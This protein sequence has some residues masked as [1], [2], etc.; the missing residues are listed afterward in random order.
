MVA[1]PR[2]VEL[3]WV[4]LLGVFGGRPWAP[5]HLRVR[6]AQQVR[7]AEL[8]GEIGL[9]EIRFA[10]NLSTQQESDFGEEEDANSSGPPGLAGSTGSSELEEVEP[11]SP[12]GVEAQGVRPFTPQQARNYERRVEA[13]G[14]RTESI[15]AE[16][17]R[18]IQGF[19]AEHPTSNVARNANELL[20]RALSW[21]PN[22][23]LPPP[24]TWD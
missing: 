8:L 22:D 13:L 1:E 20:A 14:R 2:P 3:L 19:A 23:A 4:S 21:G 5:S 18:F 24:R 10:T 16:L 17:V 6:R 12:Q 9:G 15:D 7:G 11:Q